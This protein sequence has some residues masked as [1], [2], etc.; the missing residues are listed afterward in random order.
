MNRRSL[1]LAVLLSGA[2]V[3]AAYHGHARTVRALLDAGAD[4]CAGDSRGNTA[5]VR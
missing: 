2:P 4:A 3:L 5:R 1:M